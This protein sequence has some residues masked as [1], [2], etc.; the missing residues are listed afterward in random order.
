M[1]EHFF[2][3]GKEIQFFEPRRFIYR[4]NLANGKIVFECTAKGIS[5]A[6]KLY[7]VAKGKNPEQQSH[8]GC[9]I[10]KIEENT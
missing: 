5:E 8:I 6:D 2:G 9:S 1:N 3:V 4:D 10:E 7:R